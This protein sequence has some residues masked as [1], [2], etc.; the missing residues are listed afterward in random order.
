MRKPRLRPEKG[1]DGGIRVCGVLPHPWDQSYCP[2]LRVLQF[3]SLAGYPVG[4][5]TPTHL[6]DDPLLQEWA[7]VS[8]KAPD[9]S[10]SRFW[11]PL[12]SVVHLSV[13]HGGA[14]AAQ[15]DD[16]RMNVYASDT[17]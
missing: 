15:P 13:G 5:P 4:F 14:T 8:C 3:K 1:L 11:G 2:L 6:H 7:H 10:S 9:F 16:V 17:D 12:V